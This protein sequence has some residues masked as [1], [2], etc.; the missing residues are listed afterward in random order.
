MYNFNGAWTYNINMWQQVH[1]FKIWNNEGNY[2][3]TIFKYETNEQISLDANIF[4]FKVDPKQI[5]WSL[6]A[7]C[8]N[9]LYKFSLR[10][11][12][13]IYSERMCYIGAKFPCLLR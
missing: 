7:K 13:G 1:S 4:I 11:L 12:S 5:S 10:K 9:T 8:R 2:L 3:K 6:L